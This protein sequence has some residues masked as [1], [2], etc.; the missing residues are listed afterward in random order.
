[1]LIHRCGDILS[2]SISSG[3][4]GLNGRIHN[5][6]EASLCPRHTVVPSYCTMHSR[7]VK[8]TLHPASQRVLIDINDVCASCGQIWA[9]LAAAGSPGISIS[10]SCVVS[11]IPPDAFFNRIGLVVRRTFF[12]GVPGMHSV[13]VHPESA[14]ACVSRVWSNSRLPNSCGLIV[15]F[16]SVS[17]NWCPNLVGLHVFLYNL[18][19]RLSIISCTHFDCRI[20]F[21]ALAQV[22]MLFLLG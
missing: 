10:P 22:G 1:M 7:L 13:V 4:S 6:V 2:H 3:P 5:P 9:F 17:L 21:H 19:S 20:A 18:A 16:F 14:H 12:I 8:V 15:S 11:I